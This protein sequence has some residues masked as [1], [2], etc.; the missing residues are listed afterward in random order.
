VE[1]GSISLDTFKSHNYNYIQFRTSSG[2]MDVGSV[3]IDAQGNATTSNYWPYGALGMGQS[4]DAFGG[5][6]MLGPS[7]QNS[8]SGT[9]LTLAEEG[10]GTSYVFGTANGVFA[11]DT[12]NGAILG[13]Q[14]AA[15]KNFDPSV[16]G[17]YSAVYYQKKGATT[18]QGNVETGTP[19]LNH[20]AITVSSTGQVTVVDLQGNTLVT[21]TLTPVADASYLYNPAAAPNTLADPC[22]GL[23]TFR[24][25]QGGGTQDTFVTFVNGTMLFSSF[26]SVS[27]TGN[28]YDY[29]YG[30]GLK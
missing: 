13:L 5:S 24:S 6:V 16:A 9:Y 1:A 28:G 17:T 7:F 25:S 10:G 14:K 15:T 30:V 4:P 8:P 11:V 19:V 23:F 3:S 27:V 2:G 18:G 26:S 21:A 12:P 22:Y 20:A 29:V